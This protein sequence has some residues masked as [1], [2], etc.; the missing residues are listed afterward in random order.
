MAERREKSHAIL[1]KFQGKPTVKLELFPSEQWA[2]EG[3]PAGL[4]RVRM[5]GAWHGD[6]GTWLDVPGVMALAGGLL[7]DAAG[8]P[9]TAPERPR[10]SRNQRVRVP[11]W[12]EYVEKTF[13]KAGPFLGHDGRWWVYVVGREEPVPTDSITW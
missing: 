13:V 7:A 3:A 6:K 11:T 10:L 12:G 8:L 9:A 1:L 2:D 4:F 5:D